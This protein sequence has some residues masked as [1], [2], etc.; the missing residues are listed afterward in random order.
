MPL[1]RFFLFFCGLINVVSLC[2]QSIADQQ[3]MYEL[4]M[5]RFA[6]EFMEAYNRQD[7]TA[8]RA[9]YTT[10]NSADTIMGTYSNAIEKS[11]ENS[12]ITNNIT[13]LV[14]PLDVIWSDAEHTLTAIGTYEGYGTYG[15]DADPYHQKNAYRNVMVNEDGKWKI[16]KSEVTPVYST[17]SFL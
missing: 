17:P 13:L 8:L 15:I 10:N 6:R 16:S 9:M 11:Y 5:R 4:A 3:A 1:L 7:I 14:H 12:F 2:A